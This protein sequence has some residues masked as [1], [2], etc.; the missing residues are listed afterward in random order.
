VSLW[1]S[2]SLSNFPIL[3]Q[4]ADSHDTA[5]PG[6]PGQRRSWGQG[7]RCRNGNGPGTWGKTRSRRRE[8]RELA[9]KR[10]AARYRTHPL[11]A[12]NV[13]D[14]I[15]PHQMGAAPS[16]SL[17]SS[18]L[19]RLS[20]VQSRRW[21]G[22]APAESRS[23]IRRLG[24]SLEGGADRGQA[25]SG[26]H[27]GGRRGCVTSRCALNWTKAG[28]PTPDSQCLPEITPWIAMPARR[29]LVM[30]PMP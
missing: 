18:P 28:F 1:E 6:R 3:S 12:V 9:T 15:A 24:T 13:P 17:F 25:S 21:R 7:R 20:W 2:P 5:R 10:R 27:S 19:I 30:M 8:T 29:T 14:R 11:A 23:S 16:R 22:A 26:G 4:S